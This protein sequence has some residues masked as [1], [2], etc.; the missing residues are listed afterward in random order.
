VVIPILS[1][2]SSGTLAEGASAAEAIRVLLVE[3]NDDHAELFCDALERS[4]EA[5]FVVRRVSTSEEA[6]ASAVPGAFNILLLD[7]Q[8]GNVDGV[9][10]LEEL[11]AGGTDTPTV[12][13][14]SHGSEHLA[15][16]ALRAQADDYLA[17]TEALTDEGVARTV[18]RVLERRRL[19]DQLAR[20]REEA[21]AARARDAFL[22]AASHDLKNPLTVI[23]GTT[24][25]LQRRFLRQGSL[26]PDQLLAGLT[27]I[28]NAATQMASQIEELLDV[29]R[30]RAG[31][32]LDL[33][34]LPTDVVALAREQVAS[35]QQAAEL[36]RVRL[37]AAET[38]LVGL[39][40]RSRIGRVLANLLNNAVKYSPNGGE[41]VVT[42][43]SQMDGGSQWALITVSDQGMGIPADDLPFIFD[44][45]RRSE[46]VM[47]RI[48]G[49]GIG[50]AIVRQVV[51]QHGGTVKVVSLQGAGSTFTVRLPLAPEP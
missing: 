15:A 16:R 44:Q 9:A 13:L 18:L 51:E 29:A 3:D 38:E 4:T 25:V 6:R 1:T 45:F 50:L 47:G 28:E 30:L 20:A 37:D 23:R 48:A 17:K 46:D 31:K 14:T 43:C 49:T 24:Q 36:H 32:A 2:D 26:A 5:R 34:R 19:S 22:A 41:I 8:L 21:A 27:S 42:V 10:L 39:F 35:Y 7:Y 40:D 33:D 12:L 11:R